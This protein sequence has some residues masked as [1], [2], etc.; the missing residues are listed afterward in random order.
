MSKHRIGGRQQAAK[1]QQQGQ[2]QQDAS[3]CRSSRLRVLGDGRAQRAGQVTSHKLRATCKHVARRFQQHF[4]GQEY[5]RL[6]IAAGLEEI[7][8]QQ[9]ARGKSRKIKRGQCGRSAQRKA[10]PRQQSGQDD[11]N[12]VPWGPQT[13]PAPKHGSCREESG[14]ADH[15]VDSPACV[16]KEKIT[17]CSQHK[18]GSGKT[19][20]RVRSMFHKRIVPQ[21]YFNLQ[22][23]CYISW[24]SAKACPM[25]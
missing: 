4:A 24:Q 19:Q 13:V 17:G 8:T 2:G 9:E 1:D 14:E 3:A 11:P 6:A 20:P 15:D 16:L 23:M 25:S 22:S 7:N 12:N 18:R 5:S 21:K 10:G